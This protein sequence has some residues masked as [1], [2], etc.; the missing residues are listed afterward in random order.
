MLLY[1]LGSSP[2][3]HSFLTNSL[4]YVGNVDRT[5]NLWSLSDVFESWYSKD[6]QTITTTCTDALHTALLCERWLPFLGG[7][8]GIAPCLFDSLTVINLC[9]HACVTTVTPEVLTSTSMFRLL[10]GHTIQVSLVS[11][12]LSN[13]LLV[14][15]G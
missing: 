6:S 3:T 7:E 15:S 14:A 5:N 1:G 10:G 2:L 11:D 13:V 12:A 9:M 4:F 8:L